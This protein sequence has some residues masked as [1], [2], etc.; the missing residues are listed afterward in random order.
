MMSVNNSSFKDCNFYPASY[1]SSIKYVFTMNITMNYKKAPLFSS[2]LRPG[3][4]VGD[5]AW[6]RASSSGR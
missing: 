5:E 3:A 4:P 2:C 6:C 1:I